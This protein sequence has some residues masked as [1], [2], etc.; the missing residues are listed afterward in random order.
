MY[1]TF[2]KERIMP[3]LFFVKTLSI[4]PFNKLYAQTTV[5]F[6]LYFV[7]SHR[8]FLERTDIGILLTKYT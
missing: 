8:L 5:R 7:T 2:A 6:A 3:L 1:K 4:R